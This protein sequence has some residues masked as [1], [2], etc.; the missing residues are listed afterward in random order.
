M[1]KIEQLTRAKKPT[2]K[3]IGKVVEG[4]IKCNV[5]EDFMTDI[6]T[7]D[8]FHANKE[9]ADTLLTKELNRI[10]AEEEPEII[11][12]TKKWVKTRLQTLVK[13]KS[14]QRRLLG[15]NV[16]TQ[17]ITIKKINNGVLDGDKCLNKDKFKD[18]DL[19]LFKVVVEAKKV[20]KK[21]TFEEELIKL[22]SKH[23]KF[24]QDLLVWLNTQLTPQQIME[25]LETEKVA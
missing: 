23:D 4:G 10:Y 18:A 24:A 14:V 8:I 6:I 7:R 19:G 13:A 2:K 3:D 17:L 25:E 11:A 16:K 20:A 5:I 22:M 9:N 21:E 12:N 1:E 15:E